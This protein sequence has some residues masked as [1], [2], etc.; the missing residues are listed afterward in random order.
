MAE[1]DIIQLI[2]QAGAVGI[3]LYLINSQRKEREKYLEIIANHIQHNT[4]ALEKLDEVVDESKNAT[5]ELINFL[6]NNNKK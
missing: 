4:K 3:V 2:I 6:R 5:K 1:F